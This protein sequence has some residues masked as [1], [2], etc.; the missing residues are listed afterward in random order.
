[1]STVNI[2]RA[3]LGTLFMMAKAQKYTGYVD[4]IKAIMGDNPFNNDFPVDVREIQSA[5]D[6]N[7]VCDDA[8]NILKKYLP[9]AEYAKIKDI[10]DDKYD[11]L[12]VGVASVPSQQSLKSIMLDSTKWE[13]E[14][15]RHPSRSNFY[16]V[17]FKKKS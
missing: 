13:L 9:V 4:K 6:N 1:M 2:D 17:T 10:A 16:I 14:Y 8:K 11:G 15:K 12:F 5:I 7:I 3:A